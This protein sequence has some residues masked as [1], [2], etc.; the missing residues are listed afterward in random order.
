[1]HG[2]KPSDKGINID[3][4]KTSVDYAAFRQGPPQRFYNGLKAFDIGLARQFASQGA[5]VV[6]VDISQEQIDV[7][8]ELAKQEKLDIE[9][10]VAG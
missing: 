9:F 7:A 8:R 2:L 1:M 6:G 4:G 10:K 3:W 5:K